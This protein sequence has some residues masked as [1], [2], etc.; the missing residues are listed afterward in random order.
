MYQ[1]LTKND[2]YKP[3][4]KEWLLSIGVDVVIDG[5]S[6]RNIPSN[7]IDIANMV[8]TLSDVVSKETLLA[9]I[10]FIDDVQAELDRLDK[11]KED[12]PFFQQGLNY[13][14]TA[15]VNA[16]EEALNK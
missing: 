10:P 6:T 1:K 3:L 12:N 9:Q 5:V 4:T 8:N 11:E 16:E 2:R 13:Q 15:M 7:D 14:T